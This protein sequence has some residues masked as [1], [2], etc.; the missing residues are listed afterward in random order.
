MARGS[1]PDR[2][3]GYDRGGA[4]RYRGDMMAGGLRAWLR[5]MIGRERRW[6]IDPDERDAHDATVRARLFGEK[7][8]SADDQQ[9][10]DVGEEPQ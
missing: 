10:R 7:R 1:S 6:I 2:H 4:F 8:R 5:R 9:R 3:G